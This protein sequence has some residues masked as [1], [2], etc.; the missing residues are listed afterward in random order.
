MLQ[1]KADENYWMEEFLKG[2]VHALSF[3]FDLHYKPL[4]FFSRQ[5]VQYNDEAEDI[6]SDCFF[7]LWQ[8]HQDFETPQKIKAFL[9]ISCRNASLN[10]LQHLKVKMGA[11]KHILIDTEHGT[12]NVLSLIIRTEVLDLVSKEIDL[13]PEKMQVIF[14]MMYFD[15]KN[16]NEIAEALHLSVQTVRNQKTKAIDL[17]K[18]ALFKKEV[19][20][21][22]FTAMLYTVENL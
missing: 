21:A 3:F 16:T 20:A 6:V 2:N 11:H 15:G 1:I 9:Y 19:S 22:L 14:K 8:R 7:K 4:L 18:I 10:F 5:L 12:D 13:L 17:L